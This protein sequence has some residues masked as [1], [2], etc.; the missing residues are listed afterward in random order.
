LSILVNLDNESMAAKLFE[1]ALGIPDPWFVT[2]VE[3]DEAAK[4][5]TAL[6]DQLRNRQ[7]LLCCWS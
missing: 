3:F 4:T 6:I 5:L 7:S 1:S 2:A